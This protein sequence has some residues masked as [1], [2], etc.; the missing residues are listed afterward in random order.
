MLVLP[1]PLLLPYRP[2]FD[3]ICTTLGDL[4]AQE[5]ARQ[6]KLSAL[7]QQQP[8]KVTPPELAAARQQ[9]QQQGIYPAIGGPA[10]A[11]PRPPLPPAGAAAAA[12]ASGLAPA[13]STCDGPAAAAECGRSG[14][15]G[16]QPFS[17][18]AAAE[19]EPFASRSVASL[20]PLGVGSS[21]GT[22]VSSQDS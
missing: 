22:A 8:T 9:Q 20:A 19:A 17:P 5:H 15:V 2:S 7:I 4:L 18:F 10:A 6:A 16:G 3:L 14:A 13:N 1:I 11:T 12:A 21:K